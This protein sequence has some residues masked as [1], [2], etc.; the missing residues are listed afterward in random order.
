MK[1]AL[2]IVLVLISNMA[3]AEV[4][5]GVIGQ[6]SEVDEFQFSVLETKLITLDLDAQVG[7]SELDAIL[8]LYNQNREELFRADDEGESLDPLIANYL[9]EQGTYYVTVSDANSLGGDNYFYILKLIISDFQDSQGQIDFIGD[10][11]WFE[12]NAVAGQILTATIR[13]ESIGSKLDAFLILCDSNKKRLTEN[14]DQGSSLD[15]RLWRVSVPADGTYYLAVQELFPEHGGQEYFYELDLKIE[16]SRL[17]DL[18]GDGNVTAYDAA[19][20]LQKVVGVIDEFPVQ[21]SQ[22]A[23]LSKTKYLLW[24]NFPNPCNPETWIAYQTDKADSIR[25]FDVRGRLVRVLKINSGFG[26]AHWDGKNF[27][28]QAVSSGVYFYNLGAITRKMIVRR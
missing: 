17:G 24:Q 5:E 8:V 6:D 12:F 23:P 26:L 27:L 15:S 4:W 19:L 16:G 10:V 20:I 13:A 14:D 1:A 18:S 2:C 25:I 11:D 21:G 28:G 3:N 9:L 22:N 7:G